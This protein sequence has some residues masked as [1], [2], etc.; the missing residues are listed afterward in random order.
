MKEHTVTTQESLNHQIIPSG[1]GVLYQR[2]GRLAQIG[3]LLLLSCWPAAAQLT[4]EQKLTDFQT[5]VAL[6]AKQYAPYEWKLEVEKFDLYNVAP[7]V[8]R[9][10]QSKD[11]LEYSQILAEYIGGLNDIHASYAMRSF[12]VADLHLYTDIYDGKVLIEQIDRAY[13]PASRFPFEVG[14]E[15]VLFD[16]R[17]VMEVVREIARGV[18]FANERSTMRY[19]TDLLVYRDQSQLPLAAKLGDSATIVVRKVTGEQSSY[20]IRWDKFGFPVTKM[21]PLP[22][23]RFGADAPTSP[24][25]AEESEADGSP[26]VMNAARR[27]QA[28]L[29]RNRAPGALRHL[30]GF[31]A[32]APIFRLPANFVQRLGRNRADYF[33]SGTYIA[34]G[35]RIGYIRIPE[36]EPVDFSLLFLPLR[37]WETEIAYL[38]ANTDGLVVDVMRNPGGYGCYGVDLMGYLTTKRFFTYG[39]EI[40]STLEWV[41]AFYE[42]A[43]LTEDDGLE[44]WEVAMLQNAYKDVLTAFEENRGRTGPV[45][46]CAASLDVEPAKDRLGRALGYDKPVLLLV[47][48]FTTSAGDIFASMAQ[49]NGI[50]KLYGYR[51]AGAGGAVTESPAGFYSEGSARTTI[52]MLTRAKPYSAPGYPTSIYMENIGIH[53]EIKAD[54]MTRDNL[55]NRGNAYVEGFT[56]AILGLIQDGGQE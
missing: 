22:N 51:T 15:I 47:D 38:K 54:Y 17:P 50:A 9:I 5:I 2:W 36:F 10:R 28:R 48:E 55:M 53:P 20:T 8:E 21:G 27:L 45:A 16:G 49:D 19:A 24:L 31:G 18:K 35:K 42:S 25:R 11:D 56:K 3:F 32:R 34:D 44:A 26:R 29:Q 1:K 4:F 23:V 14:D 33:H 39:A 40:R 43:Q 37:Q 41:Q 7:W 12:F 30:T 52:L 13:L 6:Y 46:L